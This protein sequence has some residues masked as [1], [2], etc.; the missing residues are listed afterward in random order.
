MNIN[1]SSWKINSV[2]KV[3]GKFRFNLIGYCFEYADMALSLKSI[4]EIRSIPI[5]M[6]ESYWGMN[7][8][9]L[10]FC[11]GFFPVSGVLRYS[12]KSKVKIQKY[13]T[14]MILMEYPSC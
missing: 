4:T 13:R 12:E 3:G 7:F 6:R 11:R 2:S 10:I 8:M 9:W 5:L 1:R 14:R